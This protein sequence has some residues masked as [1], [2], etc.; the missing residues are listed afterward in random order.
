M[1]AGVTED[2]N[3]LCDFMPLVRMSQ[4]DV[5]CSDVTCKYTDDNTKKNCETMKQMS[6]ADIQWGA[7]KGGDGA[8]MDLSEV[9]QWYL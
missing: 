2:F 4:L 8:S 7:D 5:N 1:E 6:S 3:I 9:Q